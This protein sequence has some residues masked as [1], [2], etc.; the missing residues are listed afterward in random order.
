MNDTELRERLDQRIIVT[1]SKAFRPYTRLQ[2]QADCN[3]L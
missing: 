1:A 2:A 3:F